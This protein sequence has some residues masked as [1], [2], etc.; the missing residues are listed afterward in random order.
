MQARA[1]K[2]G[3][4]PESD[5]PLPPNLIGYLAHQRI[6]ELVDLVTAVEMEIDIHV[7]FL[8]EFEDAANLPRPILV[9]TGAATQET[10]VDGVPVIPLQVVVNWFEELKQRMG[11]N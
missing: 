6:I 1:G 4:V 2:F 11:G 10:E 7:V 8:S 5:P 9:V 3:T